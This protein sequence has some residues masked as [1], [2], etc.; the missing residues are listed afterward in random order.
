MNVVIAGGSG[1]LGRALTARLRAAGHRA[2][3]LT[4]TAATDLDTLQWDGESRGAWTDAIE[5]A[6]AVVNLSGY[7]LAHWPWTAGVRKRFIQSR[8]GPGAALVEA[9]RWSTHKPALFLQVSGINYY[10]LRGDSP[11][12]ETAPA[13]SDFLARLCVRWEAATEA[14]EELGVRRVVARMA[15]VLGRSGG[16]L[17]LMCLPVRLFLGGPLGSGRQTIAWVHETDCTGA[18]RFLIESPTARG[19]YN[20]VAPN[21]TSSEQFTREVCRN[22]QR[23]YWIPAPAFA[24]RFALGGMSDLILEGRPSAPAK[25][26]AEGYQFAFPDVSAALSDLLTGA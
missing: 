7:S 22:L 15:V 8:V 3:I 23:P 9:I 16:L 4:R 11:V 20:I 18:L 5:S 21:R 6:D 1:Y 2:R 14:A 17:P 25:L 10:G 19:A 26:L 24:M 13:G 12:D